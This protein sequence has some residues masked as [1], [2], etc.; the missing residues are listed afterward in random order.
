MSEDLNVEKEGEEEQEWFGASESQMEPDELAKHLVGKIER[1]AALLERLWQ[2]VKR[3]AAAHSE[4]L[5]AFDATLQRLQRCFEQVA[6][7]L[8]ESEGLAQRLLPLPVSEVAADQLAEELERVKSLQ[9]QVNS[10]L[11]IL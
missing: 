7:R 3:E 4:R 10:C 5:V 1:K 2:E 6:Q 8:D 9:S 11:I